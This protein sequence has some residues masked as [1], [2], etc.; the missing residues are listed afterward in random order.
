MT[1]NYSNAVKIYINDTEATYSASLSSWASFDNIEEFNIGAL[2]KTV[3]NFDG[4]IDEVRLWNDTV[5]TATEVEEL[6][7][8]SVAG[9][10]LVLGA[11]SGGGPTPPANNSCTYSSGNWVI[12]GTDNCNITGSNDLDG[13]DVLVQ[14]GGRLKVEDGG[15]IFNWS[16]FNITNSTLLI[17]NTSMGG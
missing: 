10:N 15:N 3:R 1:V 5:L 16:V 7:N 17:T 11:E 4:K 9:G 2:D 13:N 12:N 6:Y 8:N 14:N